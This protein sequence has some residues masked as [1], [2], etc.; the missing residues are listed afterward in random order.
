M[1]VHISETK[2]VPLLVLLTAILYFG[3]AFILFYL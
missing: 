1:E 2:V 3:L